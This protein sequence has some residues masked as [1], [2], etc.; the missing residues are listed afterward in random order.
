MIGTFNE[1][2]DDYDEIEVTLSSPD[3]FLVCM[4]TLT[5]LGISGRDDKTLFQS[6]HIL[7]KRGKFY[8]KHFKE[9]YKMDGKKDT[10]EQSDIE[11]RN[12]IAMLL[13]EWGLVN[14]LDKSIASAMCPMNY[15]RV[16]PHK[17]KKN[18]TL[19]PKYKMGRKIKQ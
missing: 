1:H 6:C 14:V 15:I 18:F 7:H 3:K 12:R 2:Y 10:I 13:D 19:I 17:D 4:E 11:R 5:R 9:M 16:V 8:I